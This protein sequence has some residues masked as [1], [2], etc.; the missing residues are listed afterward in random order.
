[1]SAIERAYH[2]EGIEA[3]VSALLGQMTAEELIVEERVA[4]W[5]ETLAIPPRSDA[6]RKR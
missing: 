5:P 4:G 3:A 6:A 1:V 2:G